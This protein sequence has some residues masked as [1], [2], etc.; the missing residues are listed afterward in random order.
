MPIYPRGES[1]IVSVGSGANRYR[2]TFPTLAAAEEAELKELLRRKEARNGTAKALAPV[3]KGKTL[4]EAFEHTW[5]HRW[6]KLPRS[7]K[8]NEINCTAVLDGV[9]RDT[10][11]MDI[12]PEVITDLIEAFE[13]DGNSG[14]TINRK[15]ST[16]RVMLKT[17][18]DQEWLNRVPKIP[19]QD[20]TEHRDRWMDL[21]EEARVLAKCEH[22]GLY[23]LRDYIMMA[24]DTGFRRAEMLRLTP[25]DYSNGMLHLYRGETKN[26]HARTIPATKRVAEIIKRRMDLPR[27]VSPIT[28]HTLRSQWDHLRAAM[29]MKEDPQFVVHMLRHTCASRLVQRGVPLAMVQKWMGHLDIQTTLRYAHLDPDA[30]Q[31]ARA[32]LEMAQNRPAT[33]LNLPELAEGATYDF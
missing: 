2:D 23:D 4:Q 22:L 24:V 21:D 28:K 13:D 12:T 3:S 26:K 29:G 5:R 30:L 16:L 1:F 14:G 7:I 20:E 18:Y 27:L 15:L 6:A 17:A 32:A 9:G 19:M 8:T 25:A 31:G 10:Y 33:T 11:L